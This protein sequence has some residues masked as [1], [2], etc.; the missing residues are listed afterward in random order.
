MLT[1]VSAFTTATQPWSMEVD[2]RRLVMTAKQKNTCSITVM[3]SG[4]G[5]NS[6]GDYLVNVAQVPSNA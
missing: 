5:S 2:T 1:P 6:S 3:P 4:K